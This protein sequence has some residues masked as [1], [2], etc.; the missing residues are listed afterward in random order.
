[1][2]IIKQRSFGG[3]VLGIAVSLLVLPLLLFSQAA[4]QEGRYTVTITSDNA[5]RFG[6]GDAHGVIPAKVSDAV[7]SGSASD[8]YGST[9]WD[10]R[11]HGGALPPRYS[12]P[13]YGP[14]RY[15]L[16]GSFDGKYIYIAAWSD[17][18]VWQGTI[19]LLKDNRASVSYAT[20]P[21]SAWEVYATGRNKDSYRREWPTVSEMNTD[22]A[23]ANAKSGSAPG[24]IG[25]VNTS[26]CVDGNGGCRGIL[27]HCEEF[28]QARFS[29]SPG[30]RKTFGDAQFM[31]YRNPDYPD[32]SCSVA[33]IP[34]ST[35]G[36]YLIFRV[37]PLD[38]LLPP[39]PC[40]S[41]E[42]RI[43]W[44]RE[45]PCCID[46]YLSNTTLDYW[47]A[48]RLRIL[49]D[50][51]RF[52]DVLSLPGWAIERAPSA[53][54]VLLHPPDGT[55]PVCSNEAL[56]QAC[57]AGA[58]EHEAL[59][60][61]AWLAKDFSICRDTVF[62]RCETTS[63]VGSGNA[64]GTPQ[65]FRIA[66]CLPDPLSENGSVTFFN[67]RPQNLR[68]DVH[69]LLGRHRTTLYEGHCT[70][71]VHQVGINAARLSSGVYI[72]RLTSSS[73]SASRLLRIAR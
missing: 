9:V 8:I 43:E 3:R 7:F 2:L 16:D 57:L 13:R 70:A 40:D 48:I 27:L 19:A 67:D 59:M 39:P 25:W 1:M 66:G 10:V 34:D 44:S 60:E 45:I 49:S 33:T 14:E 36:E 56:I 64:D 69:D 71:G 5:Y 62:L 12:S 31:W 46:L 17:N 26:G 22:I 29:G 68:M 42:T 72:L 11:E 58:E 30:L 73:Q 52:D 6:F 20:G 23:L 38:S 4:A 61:I 21:S 63:A 15:T 37:G 47:D 32:G 24:S 18:G 51:V 41:I 28:T 54:E 53:R 35:S 65:S 50:E 55:V